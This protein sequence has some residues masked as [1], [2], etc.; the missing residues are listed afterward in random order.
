M[1]T[2]GEHASQKYCTVLHYAHIK[3]H[4]IQFVKNNINPSNYQHNIKDRWGLKMTEVGDILELFLNL[5]VTVLSYNIKLYYIWLYYILYVL[6]QPFNQ[7]YV[8]SLD[9]SHSF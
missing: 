9:S 2:I 1:I 5:L 4:D 8:E 3:K 7:G 6:A